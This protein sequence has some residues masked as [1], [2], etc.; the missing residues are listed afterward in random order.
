MTVS[1]VQ[2]DGYFAAIRK[3]V[4]DISAS[5]DWVRHDTDEYKALAAFLDVFELTVRNINDTAELARQALAAQG[6]SIGG[7]A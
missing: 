1:S 3:T 6:G 5:T 4:L 2:L 7:A